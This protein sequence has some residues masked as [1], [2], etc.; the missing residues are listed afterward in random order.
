MLS[1]TDTKPTFFVDLKIGD[2]FTL[3]LNKFPEC[4]GTYIKLPLQ[5]KPH[6]GWINTLGPRRYTDDTGYRHFYDD[7]EVIPDDQDKP[8][9][10]P[11]PEVPVSY[12]KHLLR[13]AKRFGQLRTPDSL[14]EFN[15]TVCIGD[16]D[17]CRSIGLQCDPPPATRE[18]EPW[19]CCDHNCT[20]CP[21]STLTPCPGQTL[22]WKAQPTE[23]RPVT[24]HHVRDD[25]DGEPVYEV[26]ATPDD[27]AEKPGMIPLSEALAQLD[28]P[29]QTDIPDY[30][31]CPTCSVKFTKYGEACGAAYGHCA[32]CDNAYITDTGPDVQ[33]RLSSV[34]DFYFYY[35]HGKDSTPWEEPTCKE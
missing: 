26:H 14:R 3:D 34:A 7:Q 28:D 30:A 27:T 16:C 6:Y 15:L 32:T 8:P 21:L 17:E 24:L 4:D 29:D 31:V 2:A 22:F 10:P 20:N 11:V 13:N 33:W 9:R 19:D 25:P 23:T 1:T 12:I 18:Q 35:I 5:Q